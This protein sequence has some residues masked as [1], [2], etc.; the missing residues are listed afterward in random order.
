MR[1]VLWGQS[2]GAGVA[3]VAAAADLEKP[4]RD[5]V[6]RNR[7]GGEE[8]EEGGWKEEFVGDEGEE[9][10]HREK[11]KNIRKERTPIS[12]ILLETPFVSVRAML[13]ALYP[14]KWLPY[15]YLWPFL[16]N[17]WNS[18]E[19][20]KKI[21]A[22][23][24]LR[25]AAD[26]AGHVGD[27]EYSSAAQGISLSSGKGKRPLP[28]ILILQGGRDELVPREH[29]ITLETLGTELGLD[30]RRVEVRGALHNEVTVKAA[31]KK[32]A[33]DFL[34]DMAQD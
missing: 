3:L 10:E 1:L 21:G 33:V 7:A 34:R 30:V 17:H 11:N 19:A 8:E 14:Q 4:D 9:E 31:G 2:L 6:G 5:S 20:L 23:A 15:R 18:E 28:K 22:V 12:G 27:Y 25:R 13:T 16:T 24:S 32:A 29:A 26:S